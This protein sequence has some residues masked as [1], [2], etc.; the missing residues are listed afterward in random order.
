MMLHHNS[1]VIEKKETKTRRNEETES[2]NTQSLHKMPVKSPLLC[3]FN[4]M[5]TTVINSDTYDNIQYSQNAY[6]F[7]F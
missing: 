2:P 3:N 1:I 7:T 6:Q 4:V 5:L